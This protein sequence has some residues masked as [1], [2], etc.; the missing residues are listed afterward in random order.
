M[1]TWEASATTHSPVTS[2]SNSEHKPVA[3]QRSGSTNT[4]STVVEDS[5]AEDD[6]AISVPDNGEHNEGGNLKMIV[7][8]V[9]KCLGVKDIAA[10]CVVFTYMLT[11]SSYTT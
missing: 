10:M 11:H 4:T 7:Q 6:A 5:V 9:K 1:A 2:G 8:L 3:A